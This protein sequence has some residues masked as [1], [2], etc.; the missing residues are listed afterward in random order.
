MNNS[1]V[2]NLTETTEELNARY[3]DALLPFTVLLG[4]FI[5]VGLSG[6]FLTIL[7]FSRGREFSK[8][9][10]KL[11]VIT[12]AV[13][14]MFTCVTL[15]P[16]EIFTH[17]NYLLF[18]NQALCKVKCFLVMFLA[19]ASSLTLLVISVDR[20]LK[21]V[22]PMRKQLTPGV[23]VKILICVAFVLPIILA[24]PGAL[25]CGINK[26]YMNN[27]FKEKTVVYFCES[28]DKYRYS[29]W[30]AVYKY[31]LL[32]TQLGISLIYIILYTFVMKEA[33]KQIVA[34]NALKVNP[35]P[36]VNASASEGLFQKEAHS[37]KSNDEIHALP[38]QTYTTKLGRSKQNSCK[39][40]THMIQINKKSLTS[41]YKN[42]FPTKSMV[43]FILTLIFVI[44]YIAHLCLTLKVSDIVNMSSSEFAWFVTFFRFYLV[45]NVINPLIYAIFIPQFRKSCAELLKLNA[46]HFI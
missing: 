38:A 43:W 21:V 8:N 32:F 19:S 13:I 17:R 40:N 44:T 34:I 6:N 2:S 16:V 28:E 1:T 22:Q 41:K 23:T 20:F 27:N 45:N 30:R 39:L 33:W 14:D 11:F 26:T 15:L 31:A 5:V 25:M 35:S 4:S 29:V 46:K 10:F 9:N 37:E 12:F 24:I 42:R 18:S 7:V 36:E 3:A